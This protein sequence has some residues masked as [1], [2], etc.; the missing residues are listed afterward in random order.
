MA[1]KGWTAYSATVSGTG[2]D[3]LEFSFRNDYGYFSLDNISLTASVPDG[4][5][6]LLLTTGILLGVCGAG[7][8]FRGHKT[9]A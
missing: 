5:P 7:Y 1:A 9:G 4:G 2:S 3:L 8:A 6:G